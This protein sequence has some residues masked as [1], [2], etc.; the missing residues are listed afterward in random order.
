MLVYNSNLDNRLVDYFWITAEQHILI[1]SPKAQRNTIERAYTNS[2][3]SCHTWKIKSIFFLPVDVPTQVVETV[4]QYHA[5]SRSRNLFLSLCCLQKLSGLQSTIQQRKYK[6]EISTAI[7]S[8][9]STSL[10]LFWSTTSSWDDLIKGHIYRDTSL[11]NN[12]M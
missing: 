4:S 10:L 1:K 8:Y 9:N 7:V 5:A 11:S 12:V 6:T 3:H 2:N